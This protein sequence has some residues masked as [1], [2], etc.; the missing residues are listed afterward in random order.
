MVTDDHSATP[1]S[2]E[3]TAVVVVDHGS[4]RQEANDMLN[5]FV[6]LYRRQSGRGM[7]EGAHMEL[8]SPTISDAISKCADAGAKHI[9]I[10][11]Y[12]LSRG[13]HI[14]EDI[15]KMVE[16]A[17]GQHPGITCKIAKPIGIDSLMADLIE[18][19]VQ[20]AHTT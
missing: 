3:T 10:A 11:P 5:E 2:A 1:N 7:V 16:E 19:R 8:A 15:P 14:Q 20:D 17:A 18:K 6:E 12:F 13:R 9:I 4:R